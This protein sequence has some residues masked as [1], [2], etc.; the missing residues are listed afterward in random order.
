VIIK[1]APK[2]TRRK[3]RQEAGQASPPSPQKGTE[4]ETKAKRGR[5]GQK[6]G[7]T[8][9]K[10]KRAGRLQIGNE[11]RRIGTGRWRSGGKNTEPP[12]M[13]RV[14]TKKRLNSV[15]RKGQWVSRQAA[16]GRRA[17]YDQGVFK[18]EGGV[19]L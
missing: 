6:K 3:E 9:G 2:G 12:I 17:R 10:R 8:G 1:R 14:Q 7:M 4:E 13:Q 11:G 16:E 5:R 19:K 18:R 15:K